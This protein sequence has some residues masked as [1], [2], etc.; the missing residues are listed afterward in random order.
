MANNTAILFSQYE[1][2]PPVHLYR[3]LADLGLLLLRVDESDLLMEVALQSRPRAIVIDQRRGSELSVRDAAR[4]LEDG[5]A[6]VT[7]LK[8]DAYT[9]LVPVVVIVPDDTDV[10]ERAFAAGA[11]EVIRE[12]LDSRETCARLHALLSR[13]DRDLDAHPSTRLPGS[14]QIEAELAQRLER[15]H[16]FA[17]CYVDLDHF[18]EYNDRYSY[19]E[20]DRIIRLLARLLHDVVTGVCGEQGFVGHIGGDDFILIVPF[21]TFPEVCAVVIETF[22]ELI[23]F[24][25]SEQDRQ[26]GYYLGKDRRGQ[27]HRVPIMSVSIG[28]ATNERR[29]FEHPAQISELASEM[30]AY[31]K[32]LPGSVYTVDRRGDGVA[33]SETPVAVAGGAAKR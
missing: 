1:H 12:G 11:D 22:D 24:Q 23:P 14:D 20:G 13:S 10:V 16:A 5:D 4:P 29:Q 9:K 26:A 7:R 30:K 17:V 28:V 3:W 15:G 8:A 25:Y 19:Y 2:A 31:A 27:L 32:T 6:V 21:E 33:S 18:K